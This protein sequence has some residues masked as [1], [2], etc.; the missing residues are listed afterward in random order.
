MRKQVGRVVA[1]VAVVGAV[2]S[3]CSGPDQ[4]GAAVIVG[5]TAIPL[6]E[7][8]S[9]LDVALSRTDQVAQLTAQGG[10]PPDIARGIVTREVLHELLMRRAAAEGIVVTD[11]QVD[12]EL[13]ANGGAEAVAQQSLYDVATLRERVRDDLV[14]GAL[15]RKVIAGLAVTA[16]LVAAT[17]REDAEA[18]AK[19]L[20]A[21]GPEADALLA[22]QQTAARG[23][24]YQAVT[25]PDAAGTVLFGAPVGSVVL[26]QPNPQQ[27]T[28]IVFRVV[29]RR[30]DAPSDPAAL[31]SVSRSQLAA[32]GERMLQASG[33]E[34]GIRVNPRFG[35]WDPIELRVVADGQQVGT[36]LPPTAG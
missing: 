18:K 28:W 21:G 6:E 15:A 29:E 33:E 14:A 1:A 22:D 5:S 26:F 31:S 8:Q 10:G 20:A 9:Q 11:A 17:S 36:I 2:I 13:A 27:S 30:T 24:V 23:T 19:V 35:V 16:D 12:A 7:V 32:I 25:Q 3:G 4:A 34:L